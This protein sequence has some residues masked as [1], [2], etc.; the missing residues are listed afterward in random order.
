LVVKI[1]FLSAVRNSGVPGFAVAKARLVA[2]M[3]MS[4]ASNE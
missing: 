2:S 4:Q 3:K 1:A